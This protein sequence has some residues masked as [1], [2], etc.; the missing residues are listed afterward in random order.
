MKMIKLV[1]CY[2]AKEGEDEGEDVVPSRGPGEGVLPRFMPIHRA[3]LEMVVAGAYIGV[4]SD[5]LQN[6]LGMS[7]KVLGN[8][9]RDVVKA[10]QVRTSDFVLKI[11]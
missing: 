2:D 1:K 5:F 11:K 7:S 8:Q 3:M 10:Y 6:A 4:R 9:M